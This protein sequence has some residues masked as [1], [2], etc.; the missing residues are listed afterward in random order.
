MTLK[1]MLDKCRGCKKI[2]NNNSKG[3]KG[4]FMIES[5]KRIRESVN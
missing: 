1:S 5:K 4:N 3:V 2:Q